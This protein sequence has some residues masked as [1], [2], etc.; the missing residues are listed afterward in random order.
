MKPTVDPYRLFFPLGWLCALLGVG[1]WFVDGLHLSSEPTLFIHLRLITGGFL[2]SFIT[3]FLMT[4]IPRM[5]GTFRATKMEIGLGIILI[6]M[7]IMT[8]W[9]MVDQ[10]LFY[11]SHAVL[12]VFLLV[13]GG[14]R[15]FKATRKIPVFFSHVGFAMILA[16]LGDYYHLRG[17]VTLGIHLGQMGALL[18]LVLGIGARFFSFL[19]GLP[20]EIEEQKSLQ[21]RIATKALPFMGLLLCVGLFFAGRGEKN[22]YLGLAFLTLCY[23]VFIWKVFRRAERPSPLKFAVRIAGGMIPLCF[24]LCWYDPMRFIT[25]FHFIFIGCFSLLVFS[26]STRV[27]LAH[28]GGSMDLEMRNLPLGVFVVLLV[29]SMI[30]R[31]AY[32]MSAGLLAKSFL[33]LALSF[34][35]AG[36][37]VWSV[38]FLFKMTAKGKSSCG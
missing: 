13:F 14:G 5:T 33:H 34:W 8:A 31:V 12:V 7:Q 16:L 35:I 15:I 25:W 10:R 21:D 26:V 28:G 6:L 22:A 23:L 36:L 37:L 32:G 11:Q 27:I 24:F 29:L 18:L 4:A 1:V 9:R 17:D 2:W 19:S 38:A 30:F 3:G 20:S